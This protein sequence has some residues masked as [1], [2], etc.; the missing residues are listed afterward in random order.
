MSDQFKKKHKAYA[1]EIW[2][3]DP[4]G[5]A[6]TKRHVMLLAQDESWETPHQW[7][8][9]DLTTGQQETAYIKSA[10]KY[11]AKVG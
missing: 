1:G 11:W 4:N 2:C 6:K 9:L 3:W 10:N 5:S 7:I 8:V